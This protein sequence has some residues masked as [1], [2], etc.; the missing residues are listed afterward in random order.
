M[1]RPPAAAVLPALANPLSFRI[2]FARLPRQHLRTI[3]RNLVRISDSAG[4]FAA[5]R[6]SEPSCFSTRHDVVTR[7]KFDL[8]RFE[9]A[10]ANRSW[11]LNW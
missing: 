9:F 3:P 7:D 1:L 11:S 6:F 4:A 8:R 2:Q 5:C 10:S